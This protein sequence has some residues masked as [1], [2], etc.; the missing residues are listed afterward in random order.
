MKLGVFVSD[1][2]GNEDMLE[3]LKIEGI[4][5]FLVGNGVYHAL[6]KENGKSSAVLQKQGIEYYA[7]TEDLQT[8]GFT[9]I[10]VDSKV[11]VVT[12]EDV[13]DLMMNTY[14]KLVWL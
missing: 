6:S 14:E 2:R 4:G 1:L 12:Y 9:A 8:R 7:L 3:R 11:N 13:V 5:V 10:D